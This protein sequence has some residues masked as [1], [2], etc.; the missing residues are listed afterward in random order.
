ML[1]YLICFYFSAIIDSGE[2]QT[3]ENKV[4]VDVNKK[5][6]LKT[7]AQVMALENFYKGINFSH[8]I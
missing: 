6:M 3:E 4:S 2:V 8:L 5:R 1:S 7:P